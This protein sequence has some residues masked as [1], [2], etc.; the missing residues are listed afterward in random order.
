[1]HKNSEVALNC[2]ALLIFVLLCVIIIKVYENFRK[3]E[4]F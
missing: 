3:K 4:N 2:K 1:M